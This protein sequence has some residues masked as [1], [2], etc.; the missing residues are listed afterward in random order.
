MR[1]EPSCPRCGAALR[2]PGLW[3]SAWT[4]DEHGA[5]HPLQPVVQPTSELLHTMSSR[6]AV[7][8]W[9][10]WPLPRGWL[11]TGFATAGDERTGGRATAVACSG[12]APLGGVADLVLVA[13]EP[14]V[15]LGARFAGVDGL[16]PGSVDDHRASDAKIHAAGH[17][18]AMW[19]LEA[20]PD[21]AVYVGEA[22]ACW[23]WAV[24]W[25]ASDGFLLI[26]DFV[27]TDLRDAGRDIDV[28]FGALS[29]RLTT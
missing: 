17:P 2:A 1:A 23:I 12:P 21:R 22:H 20:P 16:D 26:D 14:G 9:L 24:L 13:E 10:P 3:S 19:A 29:P 8:V 28:P 15:G 7:P 6:A 18:T 27:L 4:C 11:V 25:P 5:V